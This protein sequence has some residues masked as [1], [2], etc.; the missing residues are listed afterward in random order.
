MSFCQVCSFLPCRHGSAFLPSRHHSGGNAA[1]LCPLRFMR[2]TLRQMESRVP[3]FWY[4]RCQRIVSHTAL[5]YKTRDFLHHVGSCWM[6]PPLPQRA[7]SRWYQLGSHTNVVFHVLPNKTV[8]VLTSSVL[9]TPL[10][11]RLHCRLR[12]PEFPTEAVDF[13]CATSH[14]A[15]TCDPHG[16]ICSTITT[17]HLEWA[18]GMFMLQR[19]SSSAL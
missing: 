6:P 12:S 17:W 10:R 3:V 13:P 5:V 11:H 1:T 8:Q 18:F 2:T 16:V 4:H 15:G 9:G 19:R 7:N 14:D